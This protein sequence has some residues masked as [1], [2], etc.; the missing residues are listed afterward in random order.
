[1]V[2]YGD[3]II[4]RLPAVTTGKEM[5]KF[6]RTFAHYWGQKHTAS[7]KKRKI[8]RGLFAFYGSLSYFCNGR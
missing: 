6:Y 1:M 8:L 4:R 7:L 2:Y 5:G 3:E